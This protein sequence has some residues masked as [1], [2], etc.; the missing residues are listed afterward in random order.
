MQKLRLNYKDYVSFFSPLAI[1]GLIY[2]FL[3]LKIRFIEINGTQYLTDTE[4]I[5]KPILAII[6]IS[7]SL[8]TLNIK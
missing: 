7:F 5:T 2:Y 6:L 8:N 1:I 4:I 3:N